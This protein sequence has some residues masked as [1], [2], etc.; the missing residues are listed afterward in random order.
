MSKILSPAATAVF[1]A[2][3]QLATD[4]GYRFDT[5]RGE[6]VAPPGR[7]QGEPWYLP[8]FDSMALDGSAEQFY[9]SDNLDGKGIELSDA[10]REAFGLDPED[11]HA[12]LTYSDQGFVGIR[13]VD[14]AEYMRIVALYE[15]SDDE[16]TD[17]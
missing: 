7:Y 13:I 10:E 17:D 1:T 3:D 6:L 9:S 8:Y 2:A 16:S 12:L 11:T 4:A 15:A 5:A 14:D